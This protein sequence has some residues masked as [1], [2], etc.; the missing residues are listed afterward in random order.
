MSQG[1]ALQI[2]F[3]TIFV[4]VCA[5]HCRGLGIVSATCLCVNASEEKAVISPG[6]G[7]MSG[8]DGEE[9]G[10]IDHLF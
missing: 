5:A 8:G 4:Q 3:V 2:L 7:W 9:V 1:Q 6:G 10:A